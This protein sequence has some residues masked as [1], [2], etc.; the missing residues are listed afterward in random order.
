MNGAGRTALVTGASSGIGREI[1][2]LLAARSFDLVLVARREQR[3]SALAGELKALHRVAITVLP[4]DLAAADSMHVLSNRLGVTAQAVDVLVNSAGCGAYGPFSE[5]SAEREARM[6][7][8]NVAALTGLTKMVLP[9]M[10]A[11][12]WGVVLNVASTSAFRPGPLFAVY[13][14]TKAYVLSFSEA[15]AEELCGTGVRV[16]AVCPGIT[17]TEFVDVAGMNARALGRGKGSSARAAA[18]FA[19]QS[20]ERR[21]GVRVP[22]VVNKGLVSLSRVLPRRAVSRMALVAGKARRP[23]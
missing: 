20:M 23:T 9:G 12:R 13:A 2:R 14:A 4:A 3:L 1:A 17:D 11:R 21:S 16:V 19:V 18:R 10:L 5:I 22:G 7:S 8:L 6:I 15:I